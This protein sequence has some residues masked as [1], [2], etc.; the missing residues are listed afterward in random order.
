MYNS[1]YSFDFPFN[2][3]YYQ[4]PYSHNLYF[5]YIDYCSYILAEN[6][7]YMTQSNE[8]HADYN[9][10]VSAV[11]DQAECKT[12]R[13]LFIQSIRLECLEKRLQ[14]QTSVEFFINLLIK[15]KWTCFVFIYYYID[16]NAEGLLCLQNYIKCWV[17][18]KNIVSK[19]NLIY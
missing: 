11:R 2:V 4:V 12:S 18:K 1:M 10:K 19:I 5:T 8:T 16:D 15:G 6:L 9:H 3:F 13:E 7:K 17:N 14:R